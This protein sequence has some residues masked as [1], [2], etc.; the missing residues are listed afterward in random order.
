VTYPPRLDLPRVGHAPN[1]SPSA[2]WRSVPSRSSSF[3][4][5]PADHRRGDARPRESSSEELRTGAASNAAK[6][7]AQF[8]S[9]GRLRVEGSGFAKAQVIAPWVNHVERPFSPWSFQD[10]SPGLSVH[11]VGSE[12]AQPRC[13]LVNCLDIVDG[14]EE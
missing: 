9:T 4:V 10:F 3:D 8:T 13:A 7:L 1:P 5:D 14:E 2:W 6:G 11:L 12:Y